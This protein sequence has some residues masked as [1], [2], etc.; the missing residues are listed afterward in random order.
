MPDPA[1]SVPAGPTGLGT[2]V[3]ARARRPVP[4]ERPAPG[5]GVR[6]P[7]RAIRSLRPSFL[8][9]SR[10]EDEGLVNLRDNEN[11]FAGPHRH[12]PDNTHRTLV[13]LYAAALDVLE[14]AGPRAAAERPERTRWRW[15]PE[16][17]LPTRGAGDALDLLFRTFFEP[18]ADTVAVTPPS[19]ALFDELA[20]VHEIGCLAVPLTGT[21]HDRL[22][23]AALASSGAAGIFLC[24]PGN[25]VGTSLRPGELERLL[26]AYDGLVV[27]D[28]AY[29]EYAGR[30]S[31]RHLVPG[32]PNL[33]VV[34]SMSKALG[35]AA[36]RLGAVLAHPAIVTALRRARLPFTLPAPV[37]AEAEAALA[38]PVGL[39]R[40]IDLFVAERDRLA[41]GLRRCP[42]LGRVG[43]AAGFVTVRTE[44]P[45][46]EVAARLR[47]AGLATLPDPMGWRG[48]LRVS[49]GS[50]A[51][52]DRL[53]AV[54]TEAGRRTTERRGLP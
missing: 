37:V 34:R 13:E 51:V 47:A 3:P 24:D 39:R 11:P 26:D 19:F 5:T 16:T 20:A 33:V 23:V 22:D 28:E 4:A 1:R 14:G 25:P 8:F 31:H 12:Y 49:V 42:G 7:R 35:L 45:A 50:P 36:L 52:N 43:S 38:D 32:R 29:V 6:P 9:E 30:P 2:P 48:H 10:P 15:G 53:L 17:I 41:A 27:V 40:A 18:R 54:L 21:A 44:R 46:A